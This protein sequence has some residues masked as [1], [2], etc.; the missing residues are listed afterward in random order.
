[1][2][3]HNNLLKIT[4]VFKKISALFEK[5]ANVALHTVRNK[6]NLV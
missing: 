2:F 1:M 4:I 5:Q 3:K 6:L